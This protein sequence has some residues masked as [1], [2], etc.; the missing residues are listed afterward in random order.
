MVFYAT[1][2]MV[3]PVTSPPMEMNPNPG[4]FK[5]RVIFE[6]NPHTFIEGSDYCCLRHVHNQRYNVYIRGEYRSWIRM[7]EKAVSD[8]Y[9]RG[10]L[11]QN[12]LKSGFSVD[13]VLHS[14]AGA[15]ICGEESSPDGVS[16]R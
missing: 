4:T 11:G 5:D 13:M 9:E 2:L 8:A 7:M 1:N 14:G 12:I 15:Y 6:F 10:Y 3:V 16:G